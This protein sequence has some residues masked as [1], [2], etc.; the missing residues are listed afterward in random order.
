MYCN[1]QNE[2]YR[3]DSILHA[4]TIEHDENVHDVHHDEALNRQVLEQEQIQMAK[5]GLEKKQELKLDS[6]Q[7]LELHSL[8]EKALHHNQM[9]QRKMELLKD[10]QFQVH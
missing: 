3:D 9:V 4:L 1:H 7:E 8:Q 6:L 10:R 5:M 2:L